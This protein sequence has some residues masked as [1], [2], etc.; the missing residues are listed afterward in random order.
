MDI[1]ITPSPLRGIVSAIPSKSVAHRALI[2]AALADKPTR[3]VFEGES[4]DILATAAC[5]TALGADIR[6]GKGCY[7]VSPVSR[8]ENT[9]TA[10]LP[11]GESGST[12]RF[13]LPVTGA[14]GRTA[15][16]MPE[17][18]LP[19]RPL[20]PLYEE[21]I[22]HGCELSPPGATPF[23]IS[24]KLSPGDYS[25]DAGVSSQFISGLLFALPLLN[26][27]SRITLSGRFESFPYVE[28]TTDML[29]VFGVKTVFDGK[30]KRRF[31]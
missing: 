21:L 2:C 15:A 5:I 17:G 12:F 8:D 10:F 22:S 13:I 6:R 7:T 11:C 27:D 23:N 19:Q 18:R 28:L 25:L 16:F 4:L 9:E 3:V 30:R 29:A 24:G 20:S 26:G 31:G 1:E 14:L